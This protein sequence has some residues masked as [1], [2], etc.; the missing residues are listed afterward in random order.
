MFSIYNYHIENKKD[1]QHC[2]FNMSCDYRKFPHHTV[3]YEYYKMRG[4][5]AILSHY[6][7]RVDPKL[8]EV[9]CTIFLVPYAFTY[10]VSQ[11]D[12]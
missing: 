7:Y 4:R 10:C 8:G 11:L 6:C 12:K 9:I 1:V 3:P 5:N 2:Y